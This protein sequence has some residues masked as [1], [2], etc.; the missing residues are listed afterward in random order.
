MAPAARAGLHLVP[1]L[2]Q[3]CARWRCTRPPHARLDTSGSPARASV[4]GATTAGRGG[5]LPAM[6]GAIGPSLGLQRTG[7]ASQSRRLPPA[8][9]MFAY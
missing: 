5:G 9:P 8:S 7:A 2:G 3:V 1:G 6:D 4:S